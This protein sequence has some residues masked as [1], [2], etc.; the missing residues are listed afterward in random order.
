MKHILFILAFIVTTF[1]LPAQLGKILKNKI[2]QGVRQG[3][4]NAT[5]KTVDKVVDKLFDKT[6]KSKS[7]SNEGDS[8]KTEETKKVIIVQPSPSLKTYT[9][10]LALRC[11]N[12]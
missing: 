5:E 10:S 8:S 2:G 11:Y 9:K 4:Q 6:G 7:K 1:S 12:T 3:T